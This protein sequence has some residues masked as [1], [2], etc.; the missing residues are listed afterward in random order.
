MKILSIFIFLLAT[1]ASPLTV[2]NVLL[3]GFEDGDRTV[4]GKLNLNSSG[5][6]CA[7]DGMQVSSTYARVGTKSLHSICRFSDA[8][9]GGSKRDEFA[10]FKNNADSVTKD[11]FYNFSCY[12][13]NLYPSGV[14]DGEDFL[15]MQ[16]KST[17]QDN[18][19]FVAIWVSPDAS[20][21]YSNYVLVIQTAST[22][23]A[24]VKD[25]TITRVLAR[26]YSNSWVDFTLNIDWKSDAS[27]QTD[28]HMN[29]VLKASVT[30]QNMNPVWNPSVPRYPS[31]RCG[32]YCFGWNGG[33]DV[34][35]R[36]DAYYDEIKVGTTGTVSD[37]F[38]PSTSTE[39][40]KGLYKL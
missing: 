12:I 39:S 36:R 26:A 16:F 37:Y 29:R 18:F 40:P 10:V 21:L 30:G 23:G 35:D 8:T 31:F 3:A 27:G 1:A 13:D 11:Q 4:G 5:L 7:V 19:P 20:G 14:V 9:C 22:A 34:V 6:S 15:I 38:V 24:A 32:L 17:S 33:I 25:T 2:P 28:V